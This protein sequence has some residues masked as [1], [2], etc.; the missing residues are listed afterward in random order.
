MNSGIIVENVMN[1]S[2]DYIIDPGGMG[3][4]PDVVGWYPQMR[5]DLQPIE[6]SGPGW[7]HFSTGQ[8]KVPRSSCC[9]IPAAPSP[10]TYL[11]LLAIRDRNWS[12]EKFCPVIGLL[13]AGDLSPSEMDPNQRSLLTSIFFSSARQQCWHGLPLSRLSGSR[14][15][16]YLTTVYW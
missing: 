4:M 5:R 14:H 13:A 12:S 6:L 16:A 7:S 8:R 3:A 10:L 2:Q 15:K 9:L 1:I 11:M